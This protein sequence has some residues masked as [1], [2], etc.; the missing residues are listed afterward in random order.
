VYIDGFPLSLPLGTGQQL[1]A[2]LY[3]S[4]NSQSDATHN[5]YVWSSFDSTVASIE[6]NVGY[7]N[8]VNPG[9]TILDFFQGGYPAP[10]E[11]CWMYDICDDKHSVEDQGPVNVKPVIRG[12]VMCGGSVGRTLRD[13]PRRLLSLR[14]GDQR[15][16]NSRSWAAR[17][18][19]RPYETAT[20]VKCP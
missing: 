4:D 16:T 9:S 17:H 1:T 19:R 2:T 20:N 3:W 15:P 14:R 12:P 13:M 5:P 10:Y 7:A 11:A 6:S 8:S 18:D